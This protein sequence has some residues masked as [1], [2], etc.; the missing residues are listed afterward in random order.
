MSES[1]DFRNSGGRDKI[2]LIYKCHFKKIYET[3]GVFPS[4]E[5]AAAD[6]VENY[7][8]L[9]NDPMKAL[10]WKFTFEFGKMYDRMLR[11][12]CKKCINELEG[13]KSGS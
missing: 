5:A 11:E 2:A 10:Y 13:I 1:G 9:V 7:G 6:A 8:K 12:W 3:L 4:G